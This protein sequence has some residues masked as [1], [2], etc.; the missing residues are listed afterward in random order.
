MI[1]SQPCRQCGVALVRQHGE[2]QEHF[3]RRSFC[4]RA[5]WIGWRTARRE[6]LTPQ[7]HRRVIRSD[8]LTT[9]ARVAHRLQD[10]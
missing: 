10:A 3:D 6:R 7:S 1:K 5:C 4:D 8:T 9:S 2:R